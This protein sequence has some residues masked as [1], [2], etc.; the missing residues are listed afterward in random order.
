[1]KDPHRYDDIINLPH[2]VSKKHPH[3]SLE[4][5]SAQFAPFSPLTGYSDKLKDTA[6]KNVEF[7]DYEDTFTDDEYLEY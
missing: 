4:S 3:M 1:M 7:Y 2:H 6:K 5:R